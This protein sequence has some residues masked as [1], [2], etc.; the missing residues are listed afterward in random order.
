MN[1]NLGSMD[2]SKPHVSGGSYNDAPTQLT[3]VLEL[4]SQ[5]QEMQY[6]ID[7]VLETVNMVNEVGNNS[8]YSEILLLSFID[9]LSVDQISLR[10]DKSVWTLYKRRKDASKIS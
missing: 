1:A 3:A 10:M 6:R 7:D 4:Q 2:Y 8:I 5:I 9:G